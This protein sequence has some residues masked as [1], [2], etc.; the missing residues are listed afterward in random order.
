MKFKN[1]IQYLVLVF[2]IQFVFS[3]KT[4]FV[5]DVHSVNEM[6]Q[7]EKSINSISDTCIEFGILKN[8]DIDLKTLIK[9]KTYIFHRT[10]VSSYPNIHVWYH[11][12]MDEKQLLG[13]RYSWKKYNPKFED[14]R[15]NY[16]KNE[17]LTLKKYHSL[18]KE[19]MKKFGEPT[20]I[21]Q[22]KND[23]SRFAEQTW[24]INENFKV[25]LYVGFNKQTSCRNFSPELEMMITFKGN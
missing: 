7:Y 9:T 6:F 23:E 8:P 14:L 1:T 5:L 24:W 16:L 15:Y 17:K 10:K 13:I 4:V 3:C 19:L 21:R 20:K 12:D 11:F 25:Q 22:I 2:I 18:R